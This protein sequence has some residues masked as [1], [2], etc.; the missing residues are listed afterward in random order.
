MPFETGQNVKA[1]ACILTAIAGLYLFALGRKLK[2]QKINALIFGTRFSPS[3]RKTLAFLLM[4]A[5]KFLFSLCWLFVYLLPC[6]VCTSCLIM[7]LSQGAMEKRIFYSWVSGCIVL[8]ITGIVFTAL[9]LGRYSLWQRY[10]CL[11]GYSVISA[12]Y[13]GIDETTGRIGKIFLFRLSM[14]GWI[15]SCAF[16]LPAFFVLPYC[17]AAVALYELGTGQKEDEKKREEVPPA[18]FKVIRNL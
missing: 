17:N 13:K 16:V 10:L 5:V 1:T 14:L 12:L 15:A 11:D 2:A 3:L 4:Y 6:A 9:T 7:S 8:F 18:V